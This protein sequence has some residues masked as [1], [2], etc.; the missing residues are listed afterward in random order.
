[1]PLEIASSSFSAEGELWV[2]G[3]SELTAWCDDSLGWSRT[4]AHARAVVRPAL[5]RD[6]GGGGGEGAVLRTSSPHSAYHLA[7]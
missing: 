7:A 2:G 5:G 6:G 3:G 4:S 1:M